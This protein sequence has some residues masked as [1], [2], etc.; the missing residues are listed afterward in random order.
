MIHSS[1]SN[2]PSKQTGAPKSFPEWK[3]FLESK[4]IIKKKLFQAGSPFLRGK[5]R[6]SYHADYLTSAEQEIPD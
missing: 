3:A 2:P 5:G 6:E 4:T 1:S